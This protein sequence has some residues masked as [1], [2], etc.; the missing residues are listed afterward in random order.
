MWPSSI[1]IEM[2]SFS[3]RSK[4]TMLLKSSQSPL[5]A[6]IFHTLTGPAS[7]IENTVHFDSI[8]CKGVLPKRSDFAS[9]SVWCNSLFISIDNASIVWNSIDNHIKI[10]SS[11]FDA[12]IR[13]YMLNLIEK[14]QSKHD[15]LEVG[16]AKLLYP[17]RL[18]DCCIPIPILSCAV[19]PR[20]LKTSSCKGLLH[21][22]DPLILPLIIET[23]LTMLPLLPYLSHRPPAAN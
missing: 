18:T 4:V 3:D 22:W 2:D 14:R 11:Q 12:L 15:F 19:V 8:N 21:I 23:P 7:A 13:L 17:P 16:T 1:N 20:L 10:L 6:T 9:V 5:R